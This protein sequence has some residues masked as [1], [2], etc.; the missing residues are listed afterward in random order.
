MSSVYKDDKNNKCS[1]AINDDN[2]TTYTN[3]N[4]IHTAKNDS[5][6][7]WTVILGH[8]YTIHWITIYFRGKTVINIS[9]P[10]M[11]EIIKQTSACLR[12][13]QSILDWTFDNQFGWII[14]IVHNAKDKIPVLMMSTSMKISIETEYY[15][16]DEA[17]NGLLG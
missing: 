2:G 6:P 13:F 1:A 10:A 14:Y 15:N 12:R 11:K 8:E 4:C 16:N 9:I 3:G 5:H 7:H 17:D